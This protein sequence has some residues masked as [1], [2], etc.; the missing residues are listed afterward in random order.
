MDTATRREMHL[1][2]LP[3]GVISGLNWHN[4][5]RD[6]AFNLNTARTPTDVYSIDISTGQVDRWTHSETGGL[7]TEEFRE[8]ELVRWK[9]FDGKSISGFLIV[10]RSGS[11]E[12]GR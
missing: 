9:S 4:N 12:S 11:P 10:H 6:L 7:R 5:S 1:P 2:K 8:P 3:L